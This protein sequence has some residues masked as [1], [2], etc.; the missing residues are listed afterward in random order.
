M[1]VRRRMTD[2][3][4]NVERRCKSELIMPNQ[5]VDPYVVEENDYCGGSWLQS[6]FPT[7]VQGGLMPRQWYR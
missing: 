5:N 1:D 4:S 7:R 3:E 6:N 2:I